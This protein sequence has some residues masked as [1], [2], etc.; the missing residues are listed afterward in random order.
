MSSPESH[1]PAIFQTFETQGEQP[2]PTIATQVCTHT[3]KRY[4]LWS[5]IQEAFVGINYLQDW[6]GVIV[7]FMINS[8]GQLYFPLR[9]EHN[10]DESYKVVNLDHQFLPTFESI[11]EMCTHLYDRLEF[12]FETGISTYQQVAASAQHHPDL[13]REAAEKLNNA[14]AVTQED[15]MN[16]KKILEKLGQRQKRAPD[17]EYQNVCY[18][19]LYGAQNKWEYATSKLFIVLP[20]SARSWDDLDP[21]THHFRLHFLCDNRKNEGAQSMPQH[22]HL[23]NRAG[24]NLLKPQ[25]FFKK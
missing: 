4:V 12:A 19:M 6:N 11:L 16:R 22:V 23:A 25:D 14:V 9:I 21:S 10:P 17:W 18:N 2:S 1:G 7:L 24:Y 20:S 13:L 8:D 15:G 3:S 5:S